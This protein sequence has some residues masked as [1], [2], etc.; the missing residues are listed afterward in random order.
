MSTVR[1]LAGAIT[2]I[3]AACS[4][5]RDAGLPLDPVPFIM[6]VPAGILGRLETGPIDGPFAQDV[7]EAGA[8]AAAT[9]YY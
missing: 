9:V 6:N 1:I 5:E 2:L 3:S 8:L 7:T 4:A